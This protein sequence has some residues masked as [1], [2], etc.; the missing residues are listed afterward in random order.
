MLTKPKLLNRVPTV[1]E[2]ISFSLCGD[3]FFTVEYAGWTD[4]WG[5]CM[6]VRL[7]THDKSY[8]VQQEELYERQVSK[9]LLRTSTLK[10]RRVV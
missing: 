2:I 7:L 10:R 9:P 8:P 5:G 4:R 1:G 6:M 3:V